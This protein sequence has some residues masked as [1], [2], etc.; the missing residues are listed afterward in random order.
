MAGR[1]R[2]RPHPA[3]R[4]RPQARDLG[5]L[6]VRRPH[7]PGSGAQPGSGGGDRPDA[8]GR[9]PGR[10]AQRDAPSDPARV[11]AIHRP[12]ALGCCR[13]PRRTRPAAGAPRRRARD[14]HIPHVARRPQR[15]QGAQSRRQLPPLA[16][17]GRRPLR[18]ARRLLPARPPRVAV[19]CPLL[20]LAY[21]DDGVAPAGPTVRAAQRAP[22]GEVVRLPGGH[23]EPFM[24]GR[25]HA[26]EAQLSFLR[27]HLF[28]G[29][30]AS[31]R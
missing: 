17:G 6:R 26:A 19:Q 12:C 27:R 7:H 14:R 30:Q 1:D 2:V 4:G 22:R 25:D 21:D 24:G 15:Q 28:D 18:A 13:R 20:V 31:A 5:L 10:H 23:Y 9:R 3:R 29:S 16:A 8:A 11:P